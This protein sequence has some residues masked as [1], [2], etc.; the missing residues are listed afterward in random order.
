VTPQETAVRRF[1][2]AQDG[3]REPVPF[4]VTREAL[5]ETLEQLWGDGDGSDAG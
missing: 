4:D 3:A 2:R 5:G 1:R